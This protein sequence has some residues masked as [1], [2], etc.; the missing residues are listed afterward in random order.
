MGKGGVSDVK[1]SIMGTVFPIGLLM[2]AIIDFVLISFVL[3]LIIKGMNSLQRKKEAV[4]AP[5]EPPQY[6][7]TEKLLMEIRDN[8]ENK[9]EK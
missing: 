3:F 8:L 1:F 7:L 6:T 9:S 5:A 2:Q 4:A